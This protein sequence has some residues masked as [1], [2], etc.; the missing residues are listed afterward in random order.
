MYISEQLLNPDARRLRLSAQ[1]GV[2]H[3]VLDNRGSELVSG[4]G[5]GVTRWDLA[6]LRDYRQWAE[7]FD[8]TLDV[9]ALD[10]GSI[11]LDS[12]VDLEG[13][14]RSRDILARNVEIA[15]EA[16]IPCL[17]YNVQMVGI[18]RT[19]LRPG[20]GGCRNSAFR[21]AEHSPEAER[22][23]CR[24]PTGPASA[25]PATRTTRPIRPGGWAA[26]NTWWAAPKGFGG[27]WPFHLR[28]ATA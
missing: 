4:G 9:F 19:G 3:V 21:L 13:A 27:S 17:K 24:P 12:I 6:R 1:W 8:L 15:A 11:L 18:T 28:P 20:R 7:G 14:R 2:Q 10:V 16:G 22:A 5:G 23:W 25:W 26:S